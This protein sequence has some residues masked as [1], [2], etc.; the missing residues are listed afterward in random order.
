MAADWSMIVLEPGAIAAGELEAI[1]ADFARYFLLRDPGPALAV[2]TRR[3]RSGACEVY[4]SP[5]CA[6]YTEFIFERHP[7]EHARAPALLGTTLLVGH[8]AAVGCLLGKAREVASF[9][10]MLQQR[11]AAGRYAVRPSFLHLKAAG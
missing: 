2:F 7:A 11:L 4:F 1:R 3:A 9:R 8:T 5:A 10:D 6:I